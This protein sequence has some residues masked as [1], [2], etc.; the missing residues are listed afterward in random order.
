VSATAVVLEARGVCVEY[1]SIRD[2]VQAVRD[3]AVNI[4]SG[5]IVGLVG[6]SGAGKSTLALALLNLVRR[7]GRI[8]GGTVKFGDVDLLAMRDR[9]LTAIRGRE[10]GLVMQNPRSP[11]NPMLR[12][13]EQIS[14]VYRAHSRESRQ[15]AR[16]R[17]IEMLRLVGINDP[18]RRLDAYPHELSGGMAQRALLAIALV[19]RPRLLIADEPTSGLD[20]TVRAQIL[21][22]L[23]HT[24]RETGS[25]VLLV[26]Q[27]LGVV[28]NYCD[29]VGVMADGRIVEWASVD[30]FFARPAHE[31]SQRLMAEQRGNVMGA[32]PGDPDVG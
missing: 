16:A 18:E 24:V 11:L 26:T 25:S 2:D 29:R 32:A 30:D 28:A 23:S 15:R 21:D 9:A 19:C 8:T 3:V 17:A 27:D 6:E 20:V 4:A 13:G 1:R 31:V 7:P 10:I 12:I 14:D 22:D 5:E